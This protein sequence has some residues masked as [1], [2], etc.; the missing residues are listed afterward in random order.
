[1][2]NKDDQLIMVVRK[3][4]LFGEHNENYFEGFCASGLKNFEEVI[5]ERYGFM[6]RKFAE[7]DTNY[8]Q[9][10]G[11]A[12]IVYPKLRKVFAYQRSKKDEQYTEKRLQGKWSWGIGGHIEM[13]DASDVN[14]IQDSVLREIGEEVKMD[15]SITSKKILGYIYH[16]FGVNA[17]HLGL[18]YLIETNS[19][20][21]KPGDSESSEGYLATIK[22]LEKICLNPEVNVE[23]WSK[24]ALR[25]L[26]YYFETID[27]I[28]NTI[29]DLPF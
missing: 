29:D 16:D 8:K 20:V 9:P 13:S 4:D 24:T 22:E 17:V 10:I 21:I 11:Y 2:G 28:I 1:M 23:D 27:K 25:P 12:M 14:P 26:K 15:G 7:Q 3:E 18:L 6:T 5:L 19:K